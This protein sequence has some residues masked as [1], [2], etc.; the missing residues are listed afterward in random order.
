MTMELDKQLLLSAK[1]KAEKTAHIEAIVQ[2]SRLQ[3]NVDSRPSSDPLPQAPPITFPNLPT[4]N[5]AVDIPVPS[6]AGTVSSS[7]TVP[8]KS[9][10]SG[11][12]PMLAAVAH[13]DL[14]NRC[15]AHKVINKALNTQNGN[16]DNF[17][18]PKEAFST[19]LKNTLAYTGTSNPLP[20]VQ[21]I[22][23]I[24]DGERQ[25]YADNGYRVF[26]ADPN[27]GDILHGIGYVN[28]KKANNQEVTVRKS[29]RYTKMQRRKDMN[30]K[31]LEQL[32]KKL[33]QKVY[34]DHQPFPNYYTTNNNGNE[35]Y[36]DESNIPSNQSTTTTNNNNNNP[37]DN[38]ST[39]PTIPTTRQTKNG[40]S[41]GTADQS[42][43]TNV[44]MTNNIGTTTDSRSNDRSIPSNPL[45][46]SP[47]S[48][49]HD[50]TYHEITRTMD[51]LNPNSLDLT[52]SA[53]ADYFRF[54]AEP[55]LDQLY[56]R[57]LF[58]RIAQANTIRDRNRSEQLM[59]ERF[60]RVYGSKVIVCIGNWILR[61]Q[62]SIMTAFLRAGFPVYTVPEF[63]TSKR[64]SCCQYGDTEYILKRRSPNPSDHTGNFNPV[65]GLLR[66][67]HVP[68]GRIMN[69]DT[70]AAVNLYIAVSSYIIDG[71]RP[72][73]LKER[74]I[75]PFVPVLPGTT[76]HESM[77]RERD[78]ETEDTDTPEV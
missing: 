5:S 15:I 11:P 30:T 34:N 16:D 7:S 6:N 71:I 77:K 68:C 42:N 18:P 44:G 57:N 41:M 38:S 23:N 65:H 49:F 27:V 29:F 56:E 13:R 76:S 17:V 31:K 39:I 37:L 24:T 69:R 60:R 52:T 3:N 28:Q 62:P 51:Q 33:G 20:K 58:F 54:Q 8:S 19:S 70:N 50:K 10:S 55:I 9:S 2:W 43:F 21:S 64:C 32:R 61:H 14:D 1:K 40:T 78:D 66:C 74:T 26:V 59:V 35:K 45:P 4:E 75:P 48:P 25:F 67:K 53:R 46:S 12:T 63:F 22:E 36:K 73:Y 47:P 72:M